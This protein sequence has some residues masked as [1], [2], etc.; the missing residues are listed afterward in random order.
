MINELINKLTDKFTD[1]IFLKKGGE[2][3][4]Q[5]KALKTL[6]EKY[7]KNEALQNELRL[8]EI[9]LQGEKEIEFELS[10]ANI[11]MY[12]LHDVNMEYQDL[13]AQIDYIIITPAYTY[14]V[15]CKKLIGNITID[16]NGNFNREYYKGNNKIKEGMY[17]PLSQAQ[18]HI[19]I[20]KKIWMSRNNSLMDKLFRRD[21]LDTWNKP[22]VVMAN[23]KNVLNMRYAPKD[24]KYKVIK[25]DGLIEYLRKDYEKCDKDCLLSK[26]QMFNVADSIMQ[27]YNKSINEDY[28][29]KYE[30]L[31][32]DGES[33][34]SVTS[35]SNDNV[36]EKL[37][38]FRKSKSKEKNLPAYYIFTNDELEKIL[39][40]MPKTKYELVKANI[41]TDVK[42]KLHG[43]EIIE[44]INEWLLCIT[45]INKG[46]VKNGS[47]RLSKFYVTNIEVIW[48]RKRT[49]YKRM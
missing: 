35:V 45:V 42:V 2:L 24:Y 46:D 25:S 38:A 34:A 4:E 30:K 12:V 29:A 37:I 47:T 11:G 41:L 3:E 14:F 31:V 26:E 44:I 27:N 8:C 19:E 22:L 43:D 5:I 20:Y 1:T 36:R 18:R 17:S 39:E 15:E 6:L 28:I 9:G 23:S 10:N 13:K 40:L 16:S 7:P 49:Q 33:S 32:A 48:G 21:N